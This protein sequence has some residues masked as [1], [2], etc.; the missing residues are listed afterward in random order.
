MTAVLDKDSIASLQIVSKLLKSKSPGPPC[1][2]HAV[3]VP[4]KVF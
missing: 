2:G 1:F 3:D 4:R